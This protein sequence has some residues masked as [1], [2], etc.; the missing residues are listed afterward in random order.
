MNGTNKRRENFERG[1]VAAAESFRACVRRG[2][3]HRGPG[4]SRLDVLAHETAVP[5]EPRPQLHAND[6]EDEEDEEAQR[7]HVAQHWKRVQQQSYQDAHAFWTHAH[8]QGG[9]KKR[10]KGKETLE[11][12]KRSSI[13]T[14]GIKICSQA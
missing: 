14:R 7:Q 13:D 8:G 1:D 6:A 12:T 9:R 2:D 10:N 3:V 4:D 11:A 5:Q